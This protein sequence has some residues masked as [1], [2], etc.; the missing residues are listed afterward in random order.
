MNHKRFLRRTLAMLLALVLLVSL[1]ALGA[2]AEDDALIPGEEM[3]V[4]GDFSAPLKFQLYKES[5]GQAALSIVDGELQVDV[6]KIGRV[7]H[8]IQPYYDGFKLMQG[9]DRAAPPRVSPSNFVKTTPSILKFSLKDFA[10]LT[11]SCPIIE[12]TT[13]KIS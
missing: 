13:N 10:K 11:A 9:M 6:S 5:G 7:A 3:L 12:S 1:P 2:L 4:N 8:A